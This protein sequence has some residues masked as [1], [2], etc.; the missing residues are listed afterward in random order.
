MKKY[1]L[2][3]F[4]GLCS[5]V[6]AQDI[7]VTKFRN[8]VNISRRNPTDRGIFRNRNMYGDGRQAQLWLRVFAEGRFRVEVGGQ[9]MENSTGRYRFFDLN[10]GIQMLSIY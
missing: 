8:E 4:L 10:R 9:M 6:Y 3:A 7:R 2:L 1:L 5:F